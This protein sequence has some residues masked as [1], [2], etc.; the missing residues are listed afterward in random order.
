MLNQ[1]KGKSLPTLVGAIRGL[2]VK[3]DRVIEPHVDELRV[4]D[5]VN[6]TAIENNTEWPERGRA[7]MA[8]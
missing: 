7:N 4:M 1:R 3:E 8:E 5:V 2:P 6:S